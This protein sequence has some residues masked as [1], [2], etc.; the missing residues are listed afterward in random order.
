[1][2]IS[3]SQTGT[4]VTIKHKLINK[5]AWPVEVAAWGL[6]VMDEVGVSFI[7]QPQNETDF[8]V[9][10]KGA[11][12]I[13]L[14][15]YSRMDDERVAW[16]NKYITLKQSRTAEGN[17]KFGLSNEEGWAAYLNKG[18]LFVNRFGYIKIIFDNDGKTC[19]V[20]GYQLAN[21]G[22]TIYLCGALTSELVYY[23]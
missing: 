23:T 10:A 12:N 7:P 19:I 3:L 1:M 22:L 18:N 13:T 6:T 20:S 2:D 8:L 4:E 9:G 17:I 5:N 16:G 15:A 14:W 11:T 21:D